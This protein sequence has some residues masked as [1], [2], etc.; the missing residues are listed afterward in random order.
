MKLAGAV[1]FGDYKKSIVDSSILKI[2]LEYTKTFG[3]RVISFVKMNSC[4]KK[5]S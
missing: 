3:G 4:Q 1:G 5:E 2:A